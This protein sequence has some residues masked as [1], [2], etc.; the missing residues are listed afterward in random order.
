MTTR[1]IAIIA[2]IAVSAVGIAVRFIAQD[3]LDAEVEKEVPDENKEK[4][5]KI[6]KVTGYALY[7]VGMLVSASVYA[8]DHPFVPDI[9]IIEE[10]AEEIL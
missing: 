2:G 7:A 4:K 5:A 8:I 10:V 9:T 1:N 3:V 6:I